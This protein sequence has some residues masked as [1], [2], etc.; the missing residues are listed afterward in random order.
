[1]GLLWGRGSEGQ[2]QTYR[3]MV[4]AEDIAVNGSGGDSLR[5][6]VGYHEVVDAPAGIVLPCLE[7][8]APPGVAAG[9][10]GM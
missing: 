2:L 7:H 9:G 8:I 5:Q 6:T 1:M 4:R 10:G 3:T